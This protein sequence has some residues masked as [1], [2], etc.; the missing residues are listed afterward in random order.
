[1]FLASPRSIIQ[2]VFR[3]N[4]IKD[5]WGF[6]RATLPGFTMSIG[7]MAEALRAIA[8]GVANLIEWKPDPFIQR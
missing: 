6:S 7:D 1:M 4:L 5:D 2:N 8:G 3:H